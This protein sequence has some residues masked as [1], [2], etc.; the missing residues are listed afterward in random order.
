MPP[1]SGSPR[2]TSCRCCTPSPRPPA[3]PTA[4][5]RPRGED[6]QR[7]DADDHEHRR[8]AR[9]RTATRAASRR[10][11]RRARARSTFSP[12]FC[13]PLLPPP[14]PARPR[15]PQSAPAAAPLRSTRTHRNRGPRRDPQKNRAVIYARRANRGRARGACARAELAPRSAPRATMPGPRHQPFVARPRGRRRVNRPVVPYSRGTR[16]RT[17][18]GAR[19]ISPSPPHGAHARRFSLADAGFSPPFALDRRAVPSRGPPPP[20]PAGE[21]GR[22]SRP[23]AR[24]FTPRPAHARRRAGR[25]LACHES[26]L[27]GGAPRRLLSSKMDDA[28]PG[29]APSACNIEKKI[30][31]SWRALADIA[32]Q[33]P[34][35]RGLDLGEPIHPGRGCLGRHR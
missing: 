24:P 26:A 13:N 35:H 27:R 19:K 12:A 11:S 32:W 21:R 8:P 16:L 22:V 17:P 28:H 34:S 3:T 1:A 5:M 7:G 18:D 4:A 33:R 14:R 9:R 23:R 20:G 2:R 6:D 25:W 29:A 15:G 31:A 30:T 10:A